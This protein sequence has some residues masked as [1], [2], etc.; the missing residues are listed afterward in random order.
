[1]GAIAKSASTACV[2]S[3][4]GDVYSACIPSC[5]RTL[6][7]F[8][9]AGN[10]NAIIIVNSGGQQFVSSLTWTMFDLLRTDWKCVSQLPTWRIM[11]RCSFHRCVSVRT[12]TYCSMSFATNQFPADLSNPNPPMNDG[13]FKNYPFAVEMRVPT[14]PVNEPVSLYKG[15]LNFR[16]QGKV[17]D[18]E[19]RVEMS[20]LPYPAIRFLVG[21]SFKISL[22]ASIPLA[23]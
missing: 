12:S 2:T 9:I 5:D 11:C 10:S 14:G 21:S 13:Q 4:G 3:T 22:Y 18:G 6:L 1:M 17:L 20:W 15:K 8:R 23:S 19:G 7:S 16:S